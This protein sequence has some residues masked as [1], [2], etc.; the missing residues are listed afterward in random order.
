[1]KPTSDLVKVSEYALGANSLVV[2]VGGR[3]LMKG[4]DY[5]EID[6]HTIKIL[7]PVLAEGMYCS[8]YTPPDGFLRRTCGWWSK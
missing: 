2:S 5:Q 1:M 6:N 7:N 3:R 8:T 4:I